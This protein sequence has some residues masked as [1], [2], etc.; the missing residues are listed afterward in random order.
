MTLNIDLERM[1]ATASW[2]PGEALQNIS[3]TVLPLGWAPDDAGLVAWWREI[4][5]RETCPASCD[6][7]DYHAAGKCGRLGCYKKEEVQA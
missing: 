3:H 4:L 5:G 1:M 6:P 2:A 7:S